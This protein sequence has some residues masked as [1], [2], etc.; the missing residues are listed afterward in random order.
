[1]TSDKDSRRSTIGYVFTI[2]GTTIRWISKPQKFVSLSTTKAEY[3]VSIEDNKE[4]FGCIG[5]WRNWVRRR[6]I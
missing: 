2:G 3:V 5:S 6:R 4:I 1:M